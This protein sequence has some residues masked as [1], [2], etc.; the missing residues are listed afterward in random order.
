ML[1][2]V[3]CGAYRHVMPIPLNHLLSAPVN[4]F[5]SILSTTATA[6]E[7]V[8]NNEFQSGSQTKSFDGSGRYRYEHIFMSW[9][10]SG[11]I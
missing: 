9:T 10:D 6:N 2:T 1:K 4:T 8:C 7:S 3:F 11:A 5:C